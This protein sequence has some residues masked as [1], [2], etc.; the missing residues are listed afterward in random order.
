MMVFLVLALDDHDAEPLSPL[1]DPQLSPREETME[2]HT[3]EDL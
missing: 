3:L 2:F 1:V